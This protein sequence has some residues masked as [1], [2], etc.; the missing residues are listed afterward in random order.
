MVAQLPWH[1]AAFD[2][3][4]EYLLVSEGVHCSPESFIPVRH[5]LPTIDEALEG[6]NYQLVAF[7]NVV[8]YLVGENEI[9][10]IDPYVGFLTRAH[11]LHNALL[12]KFGKMKG[13]WRVYGYETTNLAAL[14]ETIDHVRQRCIGQAIAVIGEKNLFV[15]DEMTD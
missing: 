7:L 4:L 12:I 8:E 6:L 13:D 2:H 5:K 14:F 9:P 1:I 11:L 3:L 10:S 15:L